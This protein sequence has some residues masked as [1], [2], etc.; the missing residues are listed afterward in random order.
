MRNLPSTRVF[1][2]KKI[3]VFVVDTTCWLYSLLNDEMFRLAGWP[4]SGHP[5]R[6][7]LFWDFCGSCSHMANA[8]A[9]CHRYPLHSCQEFQHPV[10][11][12]PGRI[13]IG[14]ILRQLFRGCALGSAE[15][16][17]KTGIYFIQMNHKN[18]AQ[19]LFLSFK[20][21]TSLSS[22]ITI[23]LPAHPNSRHNNRHLEHKAQI[24]QFTRRFLVTHHPRIYRRS[25]TQHIFLR[26]FSSQLT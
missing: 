11:R 23:S 18:F 20:P 14:Y 1:K 2:F 26:S 10:N 13:S 8:P 12:P 19:I 16:P 4:V 15:K 25:L 24:R 6:A 21:Q 17:G 7:Q 22:N 9:R 3:A 5:E